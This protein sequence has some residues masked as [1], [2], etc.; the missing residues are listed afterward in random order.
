M[1]SL[2][3]ASLHNQVKLNLH[4]EDSDNFNV[5][6]LKKYDGVVIPGGFGYRGIEGKISS[7]ELLR[8]EKRDTFLTFKFKVK[9]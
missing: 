5:Q 2:N 9:G 6:D 8:K 4:W 3:H 1:E 7:I